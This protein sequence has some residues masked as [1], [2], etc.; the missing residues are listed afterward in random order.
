MATLIFA[1][2]VSHLKELKSCRDDSNA[3]AALTDNPEPP[4]VQADIGNNVDEDIGDSIEEDNVIG[5][6]F[7]EMESFE[8]VEESK[9]ENVPRELKQPDLN[10]KSTLAVEDI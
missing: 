6:E 2:L 5:E 7:Y 8:K 1:N 4:I 10:K 9:K 3:T